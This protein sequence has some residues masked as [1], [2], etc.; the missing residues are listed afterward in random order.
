MYVITIG[1]LWQ[2]SN[3]FKRKFHQFLRIRYICWIRSDFGNAL[4]LDIMFE[5]KLY[6]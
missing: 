1:K 2:T 5:K 6:I 4:R 3:E